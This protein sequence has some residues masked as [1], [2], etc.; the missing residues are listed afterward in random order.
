M[1]WKI[2]R[3]LLNIGLIALSQLVIKLV[4]GDLTSKSNIV[5]FVI[6]TAL[7]LLSQFVFEQNQKISDD[8]KQLQIELKNVNSKLSSL[9]LDMKTQGVNHFDIAINPSI[10]RRAIA[11]QKYRISIYINSDFEVDR[12]PS[13]KLI[14]QPKWEVYSSNHVPI[15]GHEHNGYTEYFLKECFLSEY[16]KRFFVYDIHMV[17]NTLGETNFTF[18]AERRDFKTEKKYIINVE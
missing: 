9:S 3:L 1:N 10:L 5:Y 15:D 4:G 18:I 6:V 13:L 14:T 16:D 7:S 2:I 11:G 17:C 8:N 12:K